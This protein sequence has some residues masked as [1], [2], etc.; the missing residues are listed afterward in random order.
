MFGHVGGQAHIDAVVGERQRQPGSPDEGAGPAA[1]RMGG[2]HLGRVG[3]DADVV[4]AGI[5]EGAREV[6]GAAADVDDGAPAM[7]RGVADLPQ[8]G[9]HGLGVGGQCAVEATRVALLVPELCEQPGGSGQGG[10]SGEHV[11]DGHR[12]SPCQR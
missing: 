8:I 2:V 4:P 10:P 7:V 6:A 11:G 5:G 9:N 1:H 12:R 3:F